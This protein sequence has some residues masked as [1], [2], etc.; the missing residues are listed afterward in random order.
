MSVFFQC[1]AGDMMSNQ[2]PRIVASHVVFG[3][4]SRTCAG[5]GICKVYSIHAAGR[6]NIPCEMVS[7]RLTVTPTHLSLC[8][9]VADCSPALIGQHFSAAQFHMEEDFYL[10]RNLSRLPPKQCIRVMAGAYSYTHQHGCIWI[11]LPLTMI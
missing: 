8:I 11:K 5:N 2:L 4:P 3:A 7:A 10:P 6:V 9:S 1:L